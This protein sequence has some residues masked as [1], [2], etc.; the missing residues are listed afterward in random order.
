M[1]FA[2]RKDAGKRL[3]ATL[4]GYKG[5]KCLVLAL[6]R[7]GVPVG[8][9]I[10]RALSCPL[11]T[12]VARKIGAPGHSEYALGA[13]A[14]GVEILDAPHV[15]LE[16]VIREEKAEMRRRMETYDSGSYSE[17]VDPETV[18]VVDDGIATGL[19][20]RAALAGLQKE[21]PEKVVAAVPCAP[22]DVAASLREEV[23]ELIVLAGGEEYLGA[24]GAY[25]DDFPQ[26]SDEEVVRL[27][28]SC[29]N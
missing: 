11:D 12:I 29:A 20:L 3:A 8:Y 13:I 24:V 18:I 28:A 1:M 17:G 10:A 6:P 19:T 22:A 26:V 21:L 14:P 16:E 9:E 15:G 25:Y 7:G 23:D 4:A 5:E 27:L 2:D